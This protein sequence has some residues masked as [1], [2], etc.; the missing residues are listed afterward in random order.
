MSRV[1][2]YEGLCALVRTSSF[3]DE[4]LDYFSS[5][6]KEDYTALA[7]FADN[8]MQVGLETQQCLATQFGLIVYPHKSRRKRP[9]CAVITDQNVRHPKASATISTGGYHIHVFEAGEYDVA[10]AS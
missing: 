10:G 6:R 5:V 7:T 3:K 4:V 9:A 2:E 1:F 8:A